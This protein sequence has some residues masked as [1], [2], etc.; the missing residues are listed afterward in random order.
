MAPKRFMNNSSLL[1]EG[2]RG[3]RLGVVFE[4]NTSV[5]ESVYSK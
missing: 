5:L 4:A 2:L 1:I 3:R